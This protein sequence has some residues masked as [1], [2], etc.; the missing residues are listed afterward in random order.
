[1]GHID[2]SKLVQ[3]IRIVHSIKKTIY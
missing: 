1:M 3:E 2:K